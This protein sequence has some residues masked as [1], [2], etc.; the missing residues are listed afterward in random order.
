[1]FDLRIGQ[2]NFVLISAYKPL[3]VDNTMSRSELTLPLDEALRASD[4][5]ICIG[6]LNRDIINPLFNNKQAKCLLYICDIYD[7]GS[8]IT[9]PTCISTNRASCLNAILTNA[10]VF[11][12]D[13]GVIETGLSDHCLVY[14]VLIKHKTDAPQG[15]K[16]TSQSFK[17]FDQKAFLC[18]LN[19]VP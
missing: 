11:A 6:D 10:P 1:M 14:V 16:I 13:S 3:S 18:D 5:M 8:L 4:N 12:K 9:S 2:R 15:R 17:N 7:L 19:T